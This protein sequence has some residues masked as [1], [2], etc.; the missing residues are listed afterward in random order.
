M[1]KQSTGE[2]AAIVFA[3]FEYRPK[4]GPPAARASQER[5]SRS[6][7]RGRFDCDY[8]FLANL[9]LGFTSSSIFLRLSLQFVTFETQ[10][11]EYFC[12]WKEVSRLRAPGV[13]NSVNAG[14]LLLD[15][16]DLGGSQPTPTSST[17]LEILP[18]LLKVLSSSSASQCRLYATGETALPKS[19]PSK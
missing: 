2:I 11:L 10:T 4:I 17:T 5:S 1:L 19:K 15:F 8:S 9:V 7:V 16:G 6:S 13:N 12:I 18:L 3:R 14:L